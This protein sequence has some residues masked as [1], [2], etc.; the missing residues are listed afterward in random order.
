MCLIALAWQASAQYPFAL[1]A[2]RDEFHERPTEA[3]HWWHGSDIAAG[4]DLQA[5]GTWLGVNRQ[6]RFAAVT[7]VREGGV[8]QSARVSRGVLVTHALESTDPLDKLQAQLLTLGADAAGYNLLF[9][10]LFGS[11]HELR[12][13]S[14]RTHSNSDELS[15]ANGRPLPSGIYALSNAGLGDDWPKTLNAESEMRRALRHRQP[16]GFWN[17]TA[18]REVAAP[19]DLPD[20][21]VGHDVERFLSASF[22]IGDSY[23]TRSTTRILGQPRASIAMTERRFDAEGNMTG[24]TQIRIDPN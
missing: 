18:S 19:E 11:K 5:G 17:V 20:T 15:V 16:D 13:I 10:D 1:V 8:E 14:N 24:S 12:Y 23:G 9:G 2:N 6:G 4:R 21:G 22:I 7:N 3:L